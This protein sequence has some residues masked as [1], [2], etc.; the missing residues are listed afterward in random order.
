[1]FHIDKGKVIMRKLSKN[2]ACKF[3]IFFIIKFIIVQKNNINLEGKNIIWYLL[4][5]NF[6][7]IMMRCTLLI[8]FPIPTHNY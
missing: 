7:M 6:N 1:M 2:S 5:I 8:V 3:S 4:S